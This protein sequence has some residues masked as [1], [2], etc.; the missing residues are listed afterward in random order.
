MRPNRYFAPLK[1]LPGPKYAIDEMSDA[2]SRSIS[3]ISR[4]MSLGT[5]LS[6]SDVL[7]R[8]QI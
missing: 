3:Q 5:Y 4:Q 1:V 6:S 2:I 8:A 7:R